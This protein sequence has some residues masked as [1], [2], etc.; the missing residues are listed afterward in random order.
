[1]RKY[2]WFLILF[3]SFIF[4]QSDLLKDL[5]NYYPLQ[6]GDYWEYKTF[7]QQMPY[8]ADSSAYSVEVIGDTTLK[9]DFSYKILLFTNIFPNQNRY[10]QFERIDSTTGC[11]YRYF[12]DTSLTNN[13]LKIDSLF[14]QSGD[15]L[16]TSRDKFTSF[17]Y[18]KTICRSI[19]NDTVFGK[20]TKIK[21][22]FNQSYIPGEEY[23]L[24]KGFGFYS[25]SSCELSCSFTNLVY[26]KINENEYGNKIITGVKNEKT[27]I[28]SFTLFQN[29][30]NPFNPSTSIIFEIPKSGEVTLRIYD[31]LGKE[32]KNIS[33]SYSHS[34]IQRIVFDGSKYSSGTY[35]YQIEFNKGIISKKMLLL[36]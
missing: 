3:P 6:D 17:G 19:E 23:K 15:T 31:S 16:S 28:K 5:L 33:K 36:K 18:Y 11:V 22:Y 25:S 4:A 9:N 12:N 20:A 1:M 24:V 13:E 29:Y 30:P 21:T 7:V 10:R 14:S 27:Q 26:A 34:G 2:L 8:P 32:I 35:I